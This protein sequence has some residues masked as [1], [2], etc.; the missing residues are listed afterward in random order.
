[1][2]PRIHRR[3]Q[4]R[5]TLYAGRQSAKVYRSMPEDI[6][7]VVGSSY[8]EPIADLVD[9]LLLRPRPTSTTVN[10]GVRENGYCCSIVLLLVVVLE[11]YVA[12][13]SFLQR[14]KGAKGTPKLRRV[15]V[16]DYLASLR[17]SFTLQKSLTEVFVLRDA[18]AHNHLWTQ[19]VSHHKTRYLILRNA[20]L[21][22]EFGDYKYT[23]S[24]NHRTRRTKARGLNIVPTKVGLIEVAKVFDV[25]WRVL[26]F[27]RRTRLLEPAAFGGNVRFRGKMRPFW[28]LRH[29][30][31]TALQP[32]V[33]GDS[34]QASLA[35]ALRASRSGGS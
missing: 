31:R 27:L 2:A 20:Q 12:R 13:V 17:K 19:T 14:Q 29:V 3:R 10:V 25:I 23:V 32:L 7:T 6:I 5:G 34:R 26:S 1:M 30:V 15:S 9:R 16:P 21:D 8:Y 18:L 22:P 28:E 24:V 4:L 33:P 11:S 35:G